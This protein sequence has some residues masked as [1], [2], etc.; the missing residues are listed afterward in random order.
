MDDEPIDLPPA[1]KKP[2]IRPQLHELAG[3]DGAGKVI[4]SPTEIGRNYGAS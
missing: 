3:S 2:Y 1:P 4:A